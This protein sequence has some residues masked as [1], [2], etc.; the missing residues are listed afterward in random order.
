[1]TIGALAV[2]ITLHA[3][4]VMYNNDIRGLNTAQNDQILYLI[5]EIKH[6]IVYRRYIRSI[7]GINIRNN[8][9]RILAH[10]LLIIKKTIY[11]M[12]LEGM[13]AVFLTSLRDYNIMII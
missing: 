6:N 9:T 13:D 5:Q 7:R 1:M 12:N 10:T 11:H 8:N 2:Y 3:Y 4:N